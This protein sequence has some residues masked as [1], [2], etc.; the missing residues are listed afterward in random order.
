[1]DSHVLRG[2]QSIESA[3]LEDPRQAAR[4]RAARRALQAEQAMRQQHTHKRPIKATSTSHI[5][6]SASLPTGRPCGQPLGDAQAPP[7]SGRSEKR[8]ARKSWRSPGNAAAA[9]TA[10]KPLASWGLAASS[11]AAPAPML[12]PHL[13]SVTLACCCAASAPADGSCDNEAV[14]SCC[15]RPRAPS[16]STKEG[17][18]SP[19][20]ASSGPI[21]PFG[22]TTE[23]KSAMCGATPGARTLTLPKSCHSPQPGAVKKPS[24]MTMSSPAR[25]ALAMNPNV[26]SPDASS[27]VMLALTPAP[28]PPRRSQ[29]ARGPHS[30]TAALC[31][32]GQAPSPGAAS[33]PA[34]QTE[35]MACL[36]KWSAW[37][38]PSSLSC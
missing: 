11:P 20:G 34:S 15:H 24:Y 38:S 33:Q 26:C 2:P 3:Q 28:R 27:R 8:V 10:S 18:K 9:S 17:P 25:L 23:R 6:C 1:M 19:Q 21:G 30:T 7:G 29:V 12:K 31:A 4:A 37:S 13:P 36:C 35:K 32:S 14:R 16:S 22:S 5:C